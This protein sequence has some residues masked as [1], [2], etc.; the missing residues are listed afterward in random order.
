[1]LG[2]LIAGF[3]DQKCAGITEIADSLDLVVL[4]HERDRLAD[5]FICLPD[6]IVQQIGHVKRDAFRLTAGLLVGRNKVVQGVFKQLHH[7]NVVVDPKNPRDFSV[8]VP[9]VH[10]R[11]FQNLPVLCARQIAKLILRTVVL[12]AQLLQHHMRRPIAD[13]AA[14]HM[15]VFDRYDRGI[16]AFAR[17]FMEHDF[18]VAAELR[19]DRLCDLLK[20]FQ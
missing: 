7:G 16:G 12:M 10:R 6:E 4:G 18:A 17:E 3:C 14:G 13:L 11:G 15:P 5:K 8:L 20:Q 1:M 2:D 19:R 9:D